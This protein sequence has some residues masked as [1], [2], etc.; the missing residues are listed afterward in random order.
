MSKIQPFTIFKNIIAFDFDFDLP[1]S[2]E[3]LKLFE[4]NKIKKIKFNKC[5]NQII[6]NLPDF[7][8]TISLGQYFNRKINKLPNDLKL[9]ILPLYYEHRI[10]NWPSKLEILHMPYY[11][12]TFNCIPHS[13]KELHLHSY[14][15]TKEYLEKI[16]ITIEQLY[17]DT[18]NIQELQG[19]LPPF[20]KGLSIT[21]LEL[22][23]EVEY[24]NRYNISDIL[25][26]PDTLK[27][28]C[29]NINMCKMIL[30]EILRLTNGS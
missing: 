30:K 8:N 29:I 7:I 3:M 1:I 5:F 2:I 4:S 17:I 27:K 21:C 20:L 12:N 24:N 16:P 13:I 14:K 9:L 19:N 15:L 10:D 18:I 23:N 6:D 28:E 11:V 26:I 22:N 25:D